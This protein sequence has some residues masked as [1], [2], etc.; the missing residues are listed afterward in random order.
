MIK[1]STHY[2]M[3][4][5]LSILSQKL[6]KFDYMLSVLGGKWIDEK[7]HK[8]SLLSSNKYKKLQRTLFCFKNHSWSS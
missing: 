4:E 5:L 8:S 3:D 1:L 2:Q 6:I 7:G